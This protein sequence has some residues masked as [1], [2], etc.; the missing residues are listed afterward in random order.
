MQ[1]MLTPYTLFQTVNKFDNYAAEDMKY[2]DMDDSMLY[3]LDL[4]DISPNVDP[5]KLIIYETPAFDDRIGGSF[6]RSFNGFFDL[7]STQPRGRKISHSECVDILFNEMHKLSH[8]FAIYGDYTDL[9]TQM[10]NHFR[11]SDGENFHSP[12]LDS[13]FEHQIISKGF[14]SSLNIISQHLKKTLYNKKQKINETTLFYN[15]SSEILNSTLPKF[16][17]FID[18]VNGL[19]ITVHDIFAQKITL[20]SL[21]RYASGWSA[22]VSYRAQDHFGLDVTDIKNDLY[23]QFRFFRIWFFLQRHKDFAFKPFM[24]NFSATLQLRNQ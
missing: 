12:L 16:N 24:T 20:S 5:Y 7:E 1:S 21:E 4:R 18:R 3:A 19:G 23:R 13:A 11:Y 22:K 9:I 8:T 6:D 14:N 2:G 17:R 15:I 10:I